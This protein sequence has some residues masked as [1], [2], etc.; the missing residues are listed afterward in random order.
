[1]N[2]KEY[3]S[4]GIIEACVM[5]LASE[6][7]MHILDCIQKNSPEVRQAV[8]EAQKTLEDLASRQAIDPPQPLKS[9][10]WARISEEKQKTPAAH[11]KPAVQVT[12]PLYPAQ[13]KYT[14]NNKAI[15]NWPAIAATILL[16]A[17]ISL[18]LYLNR[19][20]N[21]VKKQ[22]AHLTSAQKTQQ[23]AY[24]NLKSKWDLVTSPNVRT[25]PLSGV[26]KHPGMKAV[27]YFEQHS[28]E[29][30]LALENLPAAPRLQQYQLWA[31]VNGKPVSL[32]VYDQDAEAVIQKMTG[33]ASAQAFA[34]TLEKKG[35]SQTP[36]M[37]NMYV[38][39]K[40]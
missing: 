30:Y 16:L 26:E 40:V 9:A 29:V 38:M 13:N 8:Q 4:S 23:L 35:G 36:T 6:E 20:Q 12:T 39:G 5:G 11:K 18:N 3:I 22:L 15:L 37:E 2:I 27:V 14:E 7:E 25:I 28:N 31:I 1:L 10:I 21:N 24:Q 34:I 17:S 19:S 32:G 33:I